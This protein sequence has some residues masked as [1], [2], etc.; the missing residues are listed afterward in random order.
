MKGQKF[1]RLTVLKRVE[2]Q[3]RKNSYW[4]CLCDC[5]NKKIVRRQHL[6]SGNVRSCGC[7]AKEVSSRV[8]TKH[9]LEHTKAYRAWRGMISRCYKKTADSYYLYGGRGVT[10]CNRWKKSIISFYND[11]GEC[12]KNMSIERIDTNGNYCTDN[13]K[14]ATIEEQANNKRNTI[15]IYGKS[16]R[17]WSIKT[18]ISRNAMYQRLRLG[19]NHK[20]IIS[21][22]PMERIKYKS[23]VRAK[24]HGNN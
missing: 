23:R 9:G 24:L 17:H 5:G 1:E 8:H 6:L 19:W 14:W 16:L 15:R 4:E 11:M 2:K 12:P 21:L 13:C 7:L 20:D 22:S 18:G 10:V 3:N